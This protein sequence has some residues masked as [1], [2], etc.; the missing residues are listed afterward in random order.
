MKDFGLVSTKDFESFFCLIV[1]VS[2]T[3]EKDFYVIIEFLQID[4]H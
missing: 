1:S 2:V 4:K 3:I